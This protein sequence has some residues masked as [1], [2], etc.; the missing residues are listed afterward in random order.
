MRMLITLVRIRSSIQLLQGLYHSEVVSWVWF[1]GGEA[2]LQLI[3][4]IVCT[5]VKI[6]LLE[7]CLVIFKSFSCLIK[8]SFL[9]ILFKDTFT[10]HIKADWLVKRPV[11]G[12]PLP[13]P[14]VPIWIIRYLLP[15]SAA[16]GRI[17]IHTELDNLYP[18]CSVPWPALLLIIIINYYPIGFD[19]CRQVFQFPSLA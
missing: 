4:L 15:H 9:F 6:M 1:S 12:V 8:K 13:S 7:S 11:S 5:R 3:F 17:L 18:Q 16:R 19:L 2:E 14:S 10:T